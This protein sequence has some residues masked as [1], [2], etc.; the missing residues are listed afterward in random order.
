[1]IEMKCPACGA[2][3]R[4]PREKIGARLVCKKCLRV[5]HLTPTGQPV[6]GEPPLPKDA[7]KERVEREA[8]GLET[9]MW[10]EQ[11][12]NRFSK[13]KMPQLSTLGIIGG[14]ALVLGLGF[15][16][17][18][19]QSLEAR[20]RTIAQAMIKADMKPV[21]DVCVQGTEN[22]AIMWFAETYQRYLSLKLVL[23]RD[24]EFSIK[25]QGEAKGNAATVFIVFSQEGKRG[26]GSAILETTQTI[27]S[28]SHTSS[29]LEVPLFF[30]VDNWGN[31]ALDGKRTAEG[32]DMNPHQQ[33]PAGPS[34][35]AGKKKR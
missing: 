24:A 17:F 4:A 3:G 31:W 19:R 25:Q 1:M 34:D 8:I 6:L 15:W 7:P 27:P 35:P 20:A 2:A 12:G 5:F 32:G 16:L 28:L 29:K 26:E 33:Q 21:V 9:P 30:V 18:S 14:V 13:L 23:G 10:L 11:L 22:D